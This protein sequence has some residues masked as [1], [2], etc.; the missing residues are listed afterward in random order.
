MLPLR[1]KACQ[2]LHNIIMFY[3]Y[4]YLNR[5]NTGSIHVLCVSV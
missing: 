5:Y 1:Q 2:N 4:S 3:I